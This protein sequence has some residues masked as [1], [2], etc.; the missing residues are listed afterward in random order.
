MSTQHKIETVRKTVISRLKVTRLKRAS[1]GQFIEFKRLRD[2]YGN[3]IEVISK[4]PKEYIIPTLLRASIEDDD[5]E[6]FIA[7]R[8]IDASSID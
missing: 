5:L 1:T 4:H 7:A 6:I 2:W 3:H 8:W